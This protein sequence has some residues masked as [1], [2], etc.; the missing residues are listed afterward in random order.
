MLSYTLKKFHFCHKVETGKLL[1]FLKRQTSLLKI[2]FFRWRLK[3][4]NSNKNT[5]V[6]NKCNLFFWWRTCNG[7]MLVNIVAVVFRWNKTNWWLSYSRNWLWLQLHLFC[8]AYWRR[9]ID[10]NLCN[11]VGS[12]LGIAIL[13]NLSSWGPWSITWAYSAME[14]ESPSTI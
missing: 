1:V 2:I 4:K 13:I 7:R 5:G 9:T 11:C 12:P 14:Y 3:V 10:S 6:S 8:F